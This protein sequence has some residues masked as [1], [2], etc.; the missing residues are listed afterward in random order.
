MSKQLTALISR[1]L[2][3]PER[4]VAAVLDLLAAGSTIPFIAR[5]RKEASG[6]LDEVQLAA[7]EREKK[8]LDDLVK[9]RDYILATIEEQGKLTDALRREIETCWD[10]TRLE[11]IYLPYK[12]K[13][14]TRAEAARQRGLEP[15]A[16]WLW[17]QERGDVDAQARRFLNDEVTDSAAAL[18]GARDIIAERINEDEAARNR[19]RKH[20]RRSATI[21]AKPARGKK[22]EAAKY[23]DYFDFSEPLR[24]APSHRLLAMLRGEAEGLLSLTVRPDEEQTLADLERHYL[25]NNGPAARE[26]RAALHDGYQRLL[27]P[28]I[29]TEFR[30]QAKERADQEAIAVFVNNLRQLLLAPPLGNKR[31]L[32]I[33]PGFRTGCKV[34]AVDASGE[35]LAHTTVYPHPPQSRTL[36]AAEQ[37]RAFAQRYELEV[38]AIGNGTAGRETLDFCR[39]VDFGRP[40]ELFP[41]DES[42]ASIYSASEVAREEFPDQDVTVRGS[43]S[44]AR[45]LLDPLA[46]LVKLDPK[47]IGVGQY[48][49]DVNQTLLREELDRTVASCVNRVGINLNTASKHLLTYVSGLGPALAG[50]IVAYRAENGPFRAR[51]ELKKVPRLGAKAFEQAAGFL[52]IPAATNPLDNTAVHP[53]RYELVERMARD[54]GV[55]VEDL[56]ARA[57]LRKKIDLRRYVSGDEVGLPTLRDILAELAKPGLD[58][59]GEAQS[60][61][62]GNVR[63]LADL[64]EGMIL[65]GIV[66]NVTQFGAFV[67]IGIKENGL[68]HVSQLADRFVSNPADVVSLRQQVRVR[69]LSVDPER[70]RIQLSMKEV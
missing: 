2:D 18:A 31:V 50:N 52:R 30:K 12:R 10:E 49:H 37:L 42:G 69:V 32:G 29:E 21:S 43:V 7:I 35:L 67:D 5:Y 59:R 3:L 33:D 24:K 40:L 34:V 63:T 48:Q 60:F 58:P 47:S 55:G 41:V 66:T 44:I 56:I 61:E 51:R 11:D 36:E 57:D 46:E 53:E 13:R 45:R 28:G 39:G 26:V 6:N 14:K 65:P 15:L 4:G 17:K 1:E 64:R 22:E 20:F 54:L 25:Y 19:V 8:R 23:R 68:V 38:A 9:R 70:K 27:A 62:F 16:D